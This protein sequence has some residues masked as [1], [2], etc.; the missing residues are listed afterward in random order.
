MACQILK[1][2]LNLSLPASSSFEFSFAW[3]WTNQRTISLG[4][5]TVCSSA[6]FA[7]SCICW[8]RAAWEC[9]YW[10]ICYHTDVRSYR[11][12]LDITLLCFTFGICFKTC[13]WFIFALA[14]LSLR[15]TECPPESLWC[16]LSLVSCSTG[17]LLK[18]A[19]FPFQ[20][21]WMWERFLSAPMW[22][23]LKIS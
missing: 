8:T 23:G 14:L 21:F 20:M 13:I 17:E 15:I 9:A 5:K 16:F 18:K 19:T 12:Y 10:W 2:F 1:T 7:R 22:E 3:K 4:S 6:A 11:R